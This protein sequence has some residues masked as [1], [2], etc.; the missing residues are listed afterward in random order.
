MA[1]TLSSLAGAGAQF[2]DNNGV[3]LA[4]GLIYTYL[5]GTTTP[6]ATY[7]S[8]T[9]SI[10]HANPIVL[11]AAGRIA[12]GE[13]WL[14][15][16]IE[17][18]IVVK[19]SL[20]VQLG[21]YD[22]IPSI[23]DFTTVNASIAALSAALANTS[24]VTEGDALIGFKQSNTSGVLTGAV[25]R[26]VHQKLQEHISVKDFGAVGDGITDD[27]A[28]IQ[29]TLDSAL[30]SNK[31]VFLPAGT[32]C[33]K[34]SFSGAGYALLNKGVAMVGEGT[35]YSTIKALSSMQAGT[36]FIRVTPDDGGYIDFLNFSRFSIQPTNGATKYGRY[37]IFL[38]FPTS[39]NCSFFYMSD[40]YFFS[41]NDVSFRIANDTAVNVQGVPANSVI[42]RC[43][44]TEGTEL[45]GVGD[46]ITICNNV[47]RST[48][49][50]R[51]GINLAQ[52]TASGTASMCVVRENNFDC[53]GGAFIVTSG[54]NTKF[55]Y[56]NVELS[57][58]SGTANGAVVD[59]DGSGGLIPF[60][61][62]S[63]NHIG[64]F[65]TATA[66]SA[67]RLNGSLGC[68][69]ANNT[70]LTG[71]TV[72]AAILTTSSASNTNIGFNE[73]SP[74]FTN[75]YSNSGG[76][77][78]GI[79]IPLSLINGYTNTVGYTSLSC[80]R[81]VNGIVTLNGVIN[82]PATPNGIIIAV[83]P[84]GFY[85]SNL[86]RS[87][88]STVVSGSPSTGAVEISGIGELVYYG[89]NSTTR[90]EIMITFQAYPSYVAL[91]F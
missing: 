33:V 23:N 66:T 45:F 11:D 21:S 58:G 51:T 47:F 84:Y 72:A 50:A 2:F 55:L 52:T 43:F 63:G 37:C 53:M 78:G 57:A 70:I 76:T 61:E 36:D 77:T 22:N 3:P 79:E 14:T 39:T 90:I 62:V 8:N 38:N 24:N 85:P 73:I 89:S 16:G 88:V 54:R 26:T 49:S 65:G 20:F 5:A 15:T 80:M 42:E 10:A 27:T 82:A 30:T 56:N 13:V 67:I 64:I 19:T 35:F 41:G 1:V 87:V 74:T 34:E 83:L 29:A 25:G 44:F 32:Y 81:Y 71:I 86:L 68:N 91:S 6:A 69:I 12:A 48:N 40:I 7:T 17:Y 9:G 4:G 46:S 75:A 28:A 31:T 60:A 18:K 59:I